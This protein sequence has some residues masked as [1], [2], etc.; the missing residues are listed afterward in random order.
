MK[1]H[2]DMKNAKE[3]KFDAVRSLFGQIWALPGWR[4]LLPDLQDCNVDK[5]SSF[6]AEDE[7]NVHFGNLARGLAEIFVMLLP[8]T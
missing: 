3:W 7:K 6:M 2:L 1:T 4:D 8:S 5:P